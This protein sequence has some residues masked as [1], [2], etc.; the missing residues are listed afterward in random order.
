ML[1]DDF[2]TTNIENLCTLLEGCGRFLLRSEATC[3]K[4]GA[5]LETVVRKKKAVGRLTVGQVQS[6][7]NAYYQVCS[8]LSSGRADGCAV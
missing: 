1:L 8:C 7:E 2:S 4:M 3:E 5:V 6:L